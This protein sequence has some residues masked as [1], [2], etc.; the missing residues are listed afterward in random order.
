M[1]KLL[2][3]SAAVSLFIEAVFMLVLACVRVCACVCRTIVSVC[4]DAGGGQKHSENYDLD[5]VLLS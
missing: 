2:L 3:Y 1:C 5:L 4:I